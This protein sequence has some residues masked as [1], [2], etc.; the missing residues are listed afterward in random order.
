MK[1][2]FHPLPGTSLPIF[3]SDQELESWFY[4]PGYL[5][6][7][8]RIQAEHFEELAVSKTPNSP[9]AMEL[10]SR[11][12]LAKLQREEIEHQPYAPLCLTLYLNNTCNL[13]CSYCYSQPN[14][15]H[16][17]RL[18]MEVIHAA[19][20]V[21]A[22]NCRASQAR[23]TVVFHG[24][25]E[26]SLDQ[27]RLGQALELVEQVALAHGLDLFRYIATNGVMPIEKAAWLAERFD[28]IGLSCDGPEPIQSSQRPLRSGQGSTAWVE[29]TARAVHHAGKSLQ[30]RVT[31]TPA[32]IY[33]QREI[34][35][36]ICERL[37]PQK[38]HVEPLYQAG[39]T[40]AEDY[41]T[42]EQAEE[43]VGEFLQ[44][45]E[46]ARGFGVRWTSSGSRPGEIHGPYCHVFRQVLNLIPD[47]QATACFSL[48]H[49]EQLDQFAMAIGKLDPVTQRY[50]LDQDRIRRLQQMLSRQPKKC[51]RCFNQYHC[52]RGCPD[53]CLAHDPTAQEGDFR[54]QINQM[55]ALADLKEC[56]A[57]L[58]TQLTGPEQVVGGVVAA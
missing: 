18:E 34:A 26:P 1:A 44:A 5:V 51:E 49:T 2:D 19:A 42:T 9:P 52:T 45:V 41:F 56:A 8:D 36:Y 43:F 16:S 35:A 32:S 48:S 37:Q 39:L 11:A 4:A 10:Q 25:G 22:A 40:R 54:C 23:M 30:V 12:R 20:E 13:A 21:V 24:G 55:L 28:L 53:R 7:A 58:H 31:V 50:V 38:I 27:D 6:V 17:Q 15:G 46:V 3:R 47:G 33:R 29:S 14:T 57:V